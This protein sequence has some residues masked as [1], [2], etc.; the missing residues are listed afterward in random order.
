MSASLIRAAIAE[1]LKTVPE[2]GR[3]HEQLPLFRDARGFA[4]QYAAPGGRILGWHVELRGRFEALSGSCGSEV[5]HLWRIEGFA[6][7]A[8]EGAASESAFADLAEAACAAF[9]TDPTLGGLVSGKPH[10]GEIVP[11]IE[12]LEAVILGETLCHRARLRLNTISR[13]SGPAYL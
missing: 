1:R 6:Q 8:R 11:Q 3:V 2:I 9:R 12:S 13:A 10:Q 7:I 5:R 4:A